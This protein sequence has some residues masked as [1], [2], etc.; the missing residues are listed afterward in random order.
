MIYSRNLGL[1]QNFFFWELLLGIAKASLMIMKSFWRRSP[2]WVSTIPSFLRNFALEVAFECSSI[3]AKEEALGQ[4]DVTPHE[5]KNFLSN[6][7]DKS[8]F[9]SFA[10][11]F[12]ELRGWGRKFRCQKKF[13]FPK[14]LST[15]E[16][17]CQTLNRAFFSRISDFATFKTFTPIS[18]IVS[19][20][21]FL[22]MPC[23]SI[24]RKKKLHVFQKPTLFEKMNYLSIPGSKLKFPNSVCSFF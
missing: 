18:N 20:G 4:T 17:C 12:R 14:E 7:G 9:S 8:S 2:K 13:N 22:F 19:E 16:F 6:R 24:K 15:T 11:G 10:R 1:I 3:K 5:F 21:T 23:N